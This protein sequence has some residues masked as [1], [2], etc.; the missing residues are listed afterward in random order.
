MISFL[1]IYTDVIQTKHLGILGHKLKI[2]MITG[3]VDVASLFLGALC[4]T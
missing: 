2:R 4:F 3:F 1:L